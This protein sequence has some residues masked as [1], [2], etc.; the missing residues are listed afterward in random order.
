MFSI[1]YL[2]V[3]SVFVAIVSAQNRKKLKE[4]YDP[5][6]NLNHE[7]E[8]INHR[9]PNHTHPETYDLSLWTRIDLA[10]FDYQ[11][12]VKIGIVVDHPTRQIVLHKSRLTILDVKLTRVNGP[13]PIQ[14]P[15]LPYFFEAGNQQ[16]TILTNGTFFNAGERLVLKITFYNEIAVGE[17]GL[18]RY[19]YEDIAGNKT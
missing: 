17:G 15:L 13:K 12:V 4:K 16:L 8:I 3:I 10:D 18:F 1:K 6:F 14:V 9:L 2:I 11:G 7:N 5:A 19:S